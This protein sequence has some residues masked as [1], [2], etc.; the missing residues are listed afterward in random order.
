MTIFKDIYNFFF[1]KDFGPIWQ[2]FANEH[3]GA[4]T[5]ISNDKVE[6]PYKGFT[7]TFDAY[8]YYANVGNSS[9]DHDFTRGLVEFISPDS[10]KLQITQ[11]GV[12]ENIG[13]FF[14]AQDILIGDKQ[15]DKKFIVKSND[16]VKALLTLS[17]NSIIKTLQDVDTIRLDI[18]DGEGLWS[19]KPKEGNFM[20]YYV[21]D[22]KI[23]HI[24]QLN[25][26]YSLFTDTLDTLTK[27][28]S[29]KPS[30]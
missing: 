19:E 25:K 11:Q 7:I 29:I 30:S 6:F 20:L 3:Q 10:F 9:R 21:L 17:N 1:G 23:N 14:G 2:Q 27:L 22:S 4:Y 18:T 28:K 5:S 12:F 13:K 24:D 8:T 15:F 16:E 26:L